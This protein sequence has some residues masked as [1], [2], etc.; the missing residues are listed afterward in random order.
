MDLKKRGGNIFS[1]PFFQCPTDFNGLEQVPK[2]MNFE[3][4]LR[5]ERENIFPHKILTISFD[6]YSRLYFF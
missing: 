4:D 2:S 1:L 6:D 3:G 5:K